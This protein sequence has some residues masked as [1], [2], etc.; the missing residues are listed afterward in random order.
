MKKGLLFTLLTLFASSFINAQVGIGTKLPKAS[1]DVKHGGKGPIGILAPIITGD[2]LSDLDKLY[3]VDQEGAILYVTKAVETNQ[4]PK[5][6][7]VDEPGYYNYNAALELWVKLS[8][9]PEPWF[10]V[11][12][13]KGADSN[14]SDI[15]QMGKVATGTK[16]IE[17]SAQFEVKSFNKGVLI[18]RLTTAQRDKVE[19]PADGLMIYNTD[20]Q[21]INFYDL[22]LAH[23][24]SLCGSFYSD[25][26]AS[27]DCS[28]P[29]GAEG[30]YMVG[31]VLDGSN[32]IKL[33][34]TVT[35][36]GSITISIT[37]NNGYSFS[38]SNPVLGVGNH[39]L[40][41]MGIGVPIKEATPDKAVI[42][43]NGYEA[44][45][46]VDITV[47]PYTIPKNYTIVCGSISQN[48]DLI[49]GETA[50]NATITIDV[51]NNNPTPVPVNLSTNTV[52]GIQFSGSGLIQGN[53]SSK[54]TLIGSGTPST[55]GKLNFTITSDDGI[56]GSC[57]ASFEVYAQ[58]MN[59]AVRILSIANYTEIDARSI[60]AVP[61][62]YP[63]F[64]YLSATSILYN[65]NNF[66][67]NGIVKMQ[68]ADAK[69]EA[70]VT[71]TPVASIHD[72]RVKKPLQDHYDIIMINN[73]S[74]FFSID[75][76]KELGAFSK[77]GGVIILASSD[78]NS[79]NMV[80]TGLYPH[81][82][83][84]HS[85]ELISPNGDNKFAVPVANS[86]HPIVKGPFIDLS[87]KYIGQGHPNLVGL[88]DNFSA[89]TEVLIADP[90]N[91][92]GAY[93]LVDDAHNLVFIGDHIFALGYSVQAVETGYEAKVQRPALSVS[94]HP[95]VKAYIGTGLP[96]KT[97]VMVDIYNSYL[98]AN[99]MAW[100][101]EK[102][103]KNRPEL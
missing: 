54:I 65:E 24:K 45:C 70:F 68:P 8:G 86:N 67:P 40:L 39:E 50:S 100:A 72:R 60:A 59:R 12:T 93:A 41:I 103:K 74:A 20:T 46:T 35:S 98:Y 63:K 81:P 15:Y 43:I 31:T 99:I 58:T 26:I 19:D 22:S 33:P 30:P 11:T 89:T 29:I 61:D 23:W 42:K 77:A 44:D 47:E 5:T 4:S 16:L 7:N 64:N 36:E 34:V 88:R 27:V 51:T 95:D 80:F 37:T 1:M 25:A 79:V 10:D 71:S 48:G 85:R 6:A 82:G 92:S 97:N 57:I 2:E 52:D 102:A 21:C 38:Y 69:A 62:V 66:G 13:D 84:G 9:S 96:A 53:S 83:T 91:P 75:D 87:G 56:G 78:L 49:E 94:G 55:T 17:P 18:S 3:G 32:F 73:T 90:K 76:A 101:V 28:S 14:D